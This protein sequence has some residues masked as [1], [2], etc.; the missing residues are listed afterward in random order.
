MC[1]ITG[2]F[3]RRSGHRDELKAAASAMS[4][5]IVH[6]GP[7]D[8]G[9]F[10]DE[11]CGVAFGFRRLAII[12]LTPAG[13]QPMES[14]SGR[15]VLM[16]NGEV[17]N[18]A[19]LR[20]ELE[21]SGAAP[22]WRGHSDT[23]VL[24]ACFERWGVEDSVKRFIGMFAMA[25]WDRREQVLHLIRD[26]MG[27]KP[28]Y[29][30]FAGGTLL[31]GSEL[32]SFLAYPGFDPDIDRDALALYT[33]Y[34]Y[35]P[36]PYTIYRNARK[37]PAGT[38][39]S[40]STTGDP[41]PKAYW[42]VAEVAERQTAT[43]FRG[44]EEEAL[45]RLDALLHDAV[46]L[47]MISDVPLGVFLSG[48][49]DSSMV[50]AIMQQQNTSPVKTFSIGF[51]EE[52]YD[53]AR[54]AAAVARHLGTDHTE[55]YV[56]PREALDVV[57]LLPHIYD[58]PFADSSQIPTYLVSRLARERVTVSLSGDGGDE[59]FG[60]YHRYFLGRQAW[61]RVQ[62]IPA[63]LRPLISGAL[64]GVPLSVWDRIF[65]VERGVAPRRLRRDRAGERLHKLAAALRTNDPDTLYHQ[66]VSQWTNVV[67]A[68]RELPLAVTAG[69][70]GHFL[71]D[72]TER[73]MYFD[74]ISYLPDD[75]LVKVD[76]ASMAVSLEAREPLLDHR[77]VEFAWSLPLEMKIRGNR[78]KW[79]LRRLLKQ[80]IPEDLVERPKMGFGI[81]IDR[82]LREPLR[83]WAE[84]L[85]DERKLRADGFFDADQI[86][87]KWR[88]HL[89]GRGEW[90]HYIWTVLMF[91]AWL[92]AAR[93][94]A[95]AAS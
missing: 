71:R 13:H 30:G 21:S 73:M 75:I 15:F 29:Y 64:K 16:F 83:D 41:G 53:E 42:S 69:D 89:A 39:L 20:A 94:A 54:Y 28:M 11:R 3:L 93:P 7:D 56:T 23:E 35:V 14:A 34:A 47:R 82:W 70:A 33:R 12:D 91:Q 50:T 85:L 81:P 60:G 65:D 8:A 31:F 10:V 32:K 62:R 5:C 18:F 86:L 43:R 38:I 45:S 19:A 55:L 9:Q 72:H 66:V 52:S 17:Y 87:Q 95:V 6:R 51:T 68:A 79:I 77:L 67:P 92:E 46:R 76:R 40:I 84:S 49:I 24:L 25:L 59:L 37:L 57:P 78:G 36:S 74:Q 80:Y 58:E 44:S 61:G 22:A 63:R 2:L 26:R 48:G 1:G 27:V 88:E 4:R 90:Q